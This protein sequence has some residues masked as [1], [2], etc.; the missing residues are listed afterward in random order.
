MLSYGQSCAGKSSLLLGRE[1][2]SPKPP[3]SRSAT[4]VDASD[5]DECGHNL[6]PEGSTVSTLAAQ[7]LD[8]RISSQDFRESRP[9]ETENGGLLSDILRVLFDNVPA[10]GREG[11]AAAATARSAEFITKALAA[12]KLSGDDDA[13]QSS[14]SPPGL[15][16]VEA[17]MMEGVSSSRSQ[18][19]RASRKYTIAFSAWDVMGKTVRDLLAPPDCRL[20]TNSRNSSRNSTRNDRDRSS[21]PPLRVVRETAG[22][23]DTGSSAGDVNNEDGDGQVRANGS[24]SSDRGSGS[25]RNARRRGRSRSLDNTAPDNACSGSGGQPS[26]DN[27]RLRQSPANTSGVPSGYPDEFETVEAPD[28][29]TALRLLRMARQRRIEGLAGRA[30]A[31]SGAGK[32]KAGGHGRDGEGAAGSEATIG[33]VFFRVVLYNEAEETV[34]TL[35][36]VDL[37]GGWE[38]RET[39]PKGLIERTFRYEFARCLE[40]L[41]I[42]HCV[43]VLLP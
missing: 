30:G 40:F 35:H 43:G 36:V 32:R 16:D 21:S 42:R 34:S 10:E 24:G 23:G 11:Q 39:R 33:H 4:A 6:Y 18:F 29:A 41:V 27:E 7:S 37:A 14:S 22:G 5:D 3:G 15:E 38:V 2:P 13:G 25:G 20:S 31:G 12:R 26:A 9:E 28:L 8:E 1:T 19:C 17:E